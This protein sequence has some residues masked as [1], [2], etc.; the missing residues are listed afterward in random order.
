MV[1]PL[2]RQLFAEFPRVSEFL[3]T[4]TSNPI[5]REMQV[6]LLAGT[7]LNIL[8]EALASHSPTLSGSAESSAR[9]WPCDTDFVR[10]RPKVF[11]FRSSKM[12]VIYD[13][14]YR[15]PNL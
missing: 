12:D 3:R 9:K 11:F 5:L 4:A 2:G 14:R 6:G 7:S 1:V 15:R 13:L 10:R 8:R